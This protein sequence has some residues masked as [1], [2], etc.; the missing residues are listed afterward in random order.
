MYYFPGFVQLLF[1]V[2]LFETSKPLFR[3]LC[4]LN[5]E[6]CIFEFGTLRII[7]FFWRGHVSL[8][9]HGP[10]RFVL[11][12]SYLT[13][14]SPSPIFT[15]WCQ[16][17]LIFRWF[18][19]YLGLSPTLYGYACFL[20]LAPFCGRILRSGCLLAYNSLAVGNLFFSRRRHC[21]SSL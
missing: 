9:L 6:L 8:I 14:Q 16:A 11:L 15:S 1:C 2:F 13:W 17:G 12:F 20:R 21:S 3:I 19:L 10:W 7:V 18:Y 4:Q 5:A